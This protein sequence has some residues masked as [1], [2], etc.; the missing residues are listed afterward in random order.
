MNKL[1]DNM[2]VMGLITFII[3]IQIYHK[4]KRITKHETKRV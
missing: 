3:M 4:I 1:I 2:M